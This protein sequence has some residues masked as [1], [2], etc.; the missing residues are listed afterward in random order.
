MN[1]QERNLF[2][3]M[4]ENIEVT[5][6]KLMSNQLYLFVHVLLTYVKLFE[7]NELYKMRV[8]SLFK[9]TDSACRQ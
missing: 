3:A 7:I 9:N 2:K 5:K 8:S 4:V 6:K 1:I